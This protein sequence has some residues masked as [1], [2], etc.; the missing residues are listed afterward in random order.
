MV[1]DDELGTAK[2][3]PHLVS[4]RMHSGD[5]EVETF[6]CIL[7]AHFWKFALTETGMLD[8]GCQMMTSLA[9][10]GMKPSGWTLAGKSRGGSLKLRKSRDD[11]ARTFWALTQLMIRW[12]RDRCQPAKPLFTT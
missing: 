6:L 2:L 7:T 3:N 9:S 4:I 5:E 10:S 12:G 8:V 11:R 1:V